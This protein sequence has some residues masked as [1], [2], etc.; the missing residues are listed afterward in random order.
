MEPELLIVSP[1]ETGERIDKLL[2][3]HYP[4]YSR[5]YF[6]NIIEEG[7]VLLN[8][9]RVTKRFLPEEGDEIE[10]LFQLTPES[11]LEPEQIPL[12][13]LFE[14]EH[15]I[16]VNK[17]AGMVIHPAPGHP[18]GTF[19]NA[20]LGHCKDLAP[21]VDPL[22][23]GIVHRLDKET[24]GVLIAAKTSQAHQKLVRLFTTRQIKKL[25]LAVCSGKPKNGIINLPIGRHP[26]HRKAMAVIE[27]GKEAISQINLLA[28]KENFSLVQIVPQTGRTHQIRVHLK[29]IGCFIL[30][31][32]LYGNAHINSSHHVQRQLLHAYRL[33][34]SHPITG[35]LLT[36]LAPIPLDLKE[37]IQ[38]LA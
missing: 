7:F 33:E 8:G 35:A 38:K 5:T 15:L 27:G 28:T 32:S 20:L 23:P 11:T 3:L 17:P 4:H 36:L 26:T 10:V 2:A 34:F 30:G 14:D 12:E 31:D 6:Q 1:S 22:R 29:Q 13:I 9:Q 18:K 21:S 25:Y 24:S 37:W 16:A 19:V